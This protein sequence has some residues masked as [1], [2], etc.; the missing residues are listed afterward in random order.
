MQLLGW[1]LTKEVDMEVLVERCGGLDVHKQTVM[2]AVRV[3]GDNG[4]RHQ[5]V[6][7]FGTFA[8]E[9]VKLREWL[10]SFGVTQIAME[11]TGVYWRAPWYELETMTGVELL[12]VNPHH[13]KKVPGRKT[14]VKDSEWLAQLLECGLLRGS[15]VP[16][17]EISRLRDLT[18]YRTKLTRERAKE[19]QRIQKTLEDAGIKL[20]SV[21]SDVLGK[22]SRQMIGALI[23]GERDPEV[24]A[25]MAQTRM[26]SKIAELKRALVGRFE[27]H[28]ALM[29]KMHLDHVRYLDERIEQLDTEVDKLMIPF[30]P[31]TERLTTMP[32]IAKR[33]AEIIL[34]EIGGDMSRFPTP[35]DLASWAGLCPGNN[36][37]AG[38]QRSGRARKGNKA[39][40]TV[41]C[42]VAW[43]AAHTKD[44]YLQAQ[45]RRFSRRFGTKSE[46]KVIFALAHTMIVIVWH[47]LAHDSDYEDLGSDYF[48]RRNDTDYRKRY[49]V[50][51]LEKMG[52]RVVL[53]PA[54]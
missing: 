12:L 20:E 3:P 26:R 28:H 18:R 22:S 23:N 48:N 27:D 36:E 45:Y 2:A 37:S 29:L 52:N 43:A 19:A 16:P 7:E 24:L 13:V 25:E 8:D 9:L 6:R 1:H 35:Q 14:D 21:V 39:L 41:M 15:F 51:E 40:R 30:R 10:G 46:G 11:A 44:S 42:E 53:E 5:E 33:S 4:K 34:A 32:G 31:K 17:R 47:L 54:A 50:H 38:K 49:L